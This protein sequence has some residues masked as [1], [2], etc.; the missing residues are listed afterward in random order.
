MPWR[1]FLCP[2]CRRRVCPRHASTLVY[3]GW[4]ESMQWEDPHSNAAAMLHRAIAISENTKGME[5]PE[6]AGALR[7]TGVLHCL[8]KEFRAAEAE[9]RRGLAIL[10]KCEGP[11]SAE[12]ADLLQ[13]PR[14]TRTASAATRLYSAAS[15]RSCMPARSTDARPSQTLPG[16]SWITG[17]IQ[18]PGHRCAS[19]CGL[20][21]TRHCT[22]IEMSR[23]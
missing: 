4:C 13:R 6:L 15:C 16:C 2:C 17:L 1:A 23:R 18:T 22:N 8:K 12:V 14:S 11:E 20:L 10:E 5:S 19:R 21:K 7:A 9:Y 3:L